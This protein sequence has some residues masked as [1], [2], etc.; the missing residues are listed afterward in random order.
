MENYIIWYLNLLFNF[1]IF[2]V[3]LATFIFG[4]KFILENPSILLLLPFY[5]NYYQFSRVHDQN[6]VIK[7]KFSGSHEYMEVIGFTSSRKKQIPYIVEVEFRDQFE[8]AK[9]CEEYRK[10]LSLLPEYYIGKADCLNAVVRIV[11]GAAK[12]SM[13]EKKIHM[14]PW[15]ETSFML[16]KWSTSSSLHKDHNLPF[17]E[18]SQK[19]RQISPSPPPTQAQFP[20]APPAVV[21]T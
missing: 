16:M 1:D 3:T 8:I 11:C 6:Y 7:L 5:T 20:T 12:R 17:A 13:K 15:R 21:V 19:F 18:S 10:L 14:G 2:S 9:P 4:Y